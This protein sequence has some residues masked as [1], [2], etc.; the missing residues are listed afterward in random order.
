VRAVAAWG[1]AFAS[2]ALPVEAGELAQAVHQCT[3]SRA[4]ELE[5]MGFYDRLHR[6]A[7]A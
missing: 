5:R 4:L 7:K 2:A 3:R 1:H 6:R